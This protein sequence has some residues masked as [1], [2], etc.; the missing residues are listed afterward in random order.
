[1]PEDLARV[2]T[3]LVTNACHAVA[4]RAG[5]SGDGYAPELRIGS[6]RT[7]E[8]VEV[9]IRDNGVGMAPEVA[10]KIFSPF[11]TTK[12]SSRITGLG[13]TLSHEIVREHGGQI[14]PVSQ[15]GEYTEMTVQLLR[16]PGASSGSNEAKSAD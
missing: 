15:P 7:A 5:L 6:R 3:N 1:M 14:V 16:D 12:E 4:E 13:L 11:F 10:A 9:T 8:R 2:F